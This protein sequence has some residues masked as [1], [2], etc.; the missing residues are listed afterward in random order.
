MTIIYLK[1]TSTAPIPFK[2]K[3]KLLQWHLDMFLH[4]CLLHLFHVDPKLLTHSTACSSLMIH[5]QFSVAT[6]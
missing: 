6:F 5:I 3:P 4:L 1:Y 2:T